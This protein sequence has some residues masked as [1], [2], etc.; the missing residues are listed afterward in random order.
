MPLFFNIKSI[1]RDLKTL[2]VAIINLTS[3][4]AYGVGSSSVSIA[5]MALGMP[6]FLS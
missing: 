2:V 3:I 5:N 1:S 6:P 4:I